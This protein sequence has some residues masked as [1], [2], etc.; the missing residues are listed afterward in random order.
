MR[1]GGGWGGG[2]AAT[3][4]FVGA[5]FLADVHLVGTTFSRLTKL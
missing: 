2:A 1:G 3:L 5:K 4:Y